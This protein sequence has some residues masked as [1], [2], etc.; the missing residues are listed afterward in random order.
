MG[1][2]AAALHEAADATLRPRV[3]AAVRDALTPYVTEQGVRMA[4]ASW[5]V[6]ARG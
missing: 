1:P 3:A 5:I 4:S 2:T 6:T